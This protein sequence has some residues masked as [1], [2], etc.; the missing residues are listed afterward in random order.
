MTIRS[1]EY[2]KALFTE[3]R[4]PQQEDFEDLID[5]LFESEE[6]HPGGAYTPT[7]AALAN[8]GTVDQIYGSYEGVNGVITV[9]VNARVNVTSHNTISQVSFT[10]PVDSTIDNGLVHLRGLV[11]VIDTTPI[12]GYITAN[13]NKAIAYWKSG[14]NSGNMNIILAFQ[15]EVR[16]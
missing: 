12:N 14:S 13:G 15:Y 2:L 1:K 10:L 6:V 9:M 4:K 7:A 8:V 16:P 5:T 3:G 11:H